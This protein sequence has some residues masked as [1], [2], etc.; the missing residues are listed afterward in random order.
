MITKATHV[1]TW[2]PEGKLDFTSLWVLRAN[3]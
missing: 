3:T 1:L 2:H